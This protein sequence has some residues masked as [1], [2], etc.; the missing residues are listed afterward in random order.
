MKDYAT[1]LTNKAGAFPTVTA[2][3]ASAASTA[4]GSEWI[5][6]IIDEWM[7]DQAFLKHAGITPSGVTDTASGTGPT[8][9][10]ASSDRLVAIQRIAGAPGELVGWFGANGDPSLGV[11]N[12]GRILPL[13]GQTVAIVDYPDLVAATYKGNATNATTAAFYKVD[14]AG[15]RNVAGPNYV[16]PNGIGQFMRGLDSGATIDADGAGRVVGDLEAAAVGDHTHYGLYSLNNENAAV[17]SADDFGTE[18]AADWRGGA[19]T[20]SVLTDTYSSK[21]Y[22][23]FATQRASGAVIR[24]ADN[25][26]VNMAVRWCIRY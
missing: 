1:I 11:G 8:G 3:N 24:T 4:D 9:T 5:K 7:G 25:R 26:P 19:V 10:S 13:V 15:A 22:T 14:G 21:V 23:G 12:N 6:A 20:R 16:L 17:P 18:T 2:V